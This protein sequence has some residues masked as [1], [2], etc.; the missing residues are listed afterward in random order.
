MRPD[1]EE[2]FDA[3][4]RARGEHFLRVAVLLTGSPTEAEDLLQASLV[5][6]YMAWPRLDAPESAPDAYLRKILVNTRR[7]WWRTKWRQESPVAAVPDRP[8]PAGGGA[9]PA[10]RY[11]LGALV[12]SALA[13]LPRQQRAVLVLRYVE[14]LPE[15][16]IADVLGVSVGTV[17]THAHRGLRAL[18]AS[19]GD[20]GPFAVNETAGPDGA[21]G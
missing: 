2:S 11:V 6:L 7:S 14:D 1:L 18:R 9:D 21:R 20:L 15:A 12:R 10:D 17:K 16:S 13:V 3:F 5:R 19:L 4:V 8:D